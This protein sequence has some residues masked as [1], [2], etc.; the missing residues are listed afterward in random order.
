MKIE[1]QTKNIKSTGGYKLY[2]SY[3]GYLKDIKPIFD[4]RYNQC[5][6]KMDFKIHS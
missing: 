5:Y 3:K 1:N 2:K 6:I 4:I